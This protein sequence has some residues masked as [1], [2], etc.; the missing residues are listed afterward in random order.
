LTRAPA[1]K[2]VSLIVYD[3][4]GTLVDTL[5]DIA[6]ALNLT[7]GE[8]GRKELS[9]GEVS[10]CVGRGVVML[11]TQALGGEGDIPR[12]VEIFRGHYGRHLIKHTR[13]YPGVRETVRGFSGLRQAICSNKPEDFVRAILTRLDFEK[14][15]Q[16]VVG[17]DTAQAPKPDPAGLNLIMDRLGVHANETVMVGDSPV[18]IATGRAAGVATLAVCYGNASR[19]AL[20][21]E[22]PDALLE[23]FSDLTRYVN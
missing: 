6:F 5:E 12:A 22:R 19:E 18:D 16:M 21:K 2:K 10:R 4:D 20:A 1:L 11:I 7:L 14:P 3:F 17:G 13:L 23:S 15:F 8:L 9:L